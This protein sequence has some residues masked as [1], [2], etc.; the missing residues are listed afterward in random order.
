MPNVFKWSTVNIKTG[1]GDGG[2]HK[3]QWVERQQ[4]SSQSL[5]WCVMAAK[6]VNKHG[7]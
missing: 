6:Y 2:A 7:S 3:T 4:V 5:L 1:F